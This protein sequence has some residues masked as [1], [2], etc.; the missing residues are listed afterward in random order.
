MRTNRPY[1]VTMAHNVLEGGFNS[2][3][4]DLPKL[5]SP[6]F[7]S[8]LH[9]AEWKKDGSMLFLR[10]LQ[11]SELKKPQGSRLRSTIEFRTTLPE[12]THT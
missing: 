3:L 4:V 11:E 10:S 8:T 7:S 2:G 1:T 9:T 12:T 6:V 5:K